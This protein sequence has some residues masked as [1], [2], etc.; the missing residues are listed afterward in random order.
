MDSGSNS[1]DNKLT[2]SLNKSFSDD[3]GNFTFKC[4]DLN[5]RK[6]DV[7]LHFESSVAVATQ[8][9][10]ECFTENLELINSTTVDL[11]QGNQGSGVW[12]TRRLIRIDEP[13]LLRGIEVI[14]IGAV[15]VANTT[16]IESAKKCYSNMNK[17]AI[18]HQKNTLNLY[19][20]ANNNLDEKNYESV[21]ELHDELFTGL[22]ELRKEYNAAVSDEVK[23]LSKHLH[24][25]KQSYNKNPTSELEEKI[26]QLNDMKMAFH[27]AT[28]KQS[29]IEGK[30]VKFV[31]VVEKKFIL[32]D[33]KETLSV[34]QH[35]TKAENRELKIINK[36]LDSTKYVSGKSRERLEHKRGKIL[37]KLEKVEDIGSIKKLT[38][39][40]KLAKLL[41]KP[42]RFIQKIISKITGIP[43]ELDAVIMKLARPPSAD[44]MVNLNTSIQK[45]LDACGDNP[46]VL[47]RKDAMVGYVTDEPLL[48]WGSTYEGH[49]LSNPANWVDITDIS[50][51]I[52]PNGKAHIFE[53][54]EEAQGIERDGKV[55]GGVPSGLRGSEGYNT[56]AANMLKTTVSR[57]TDIL[58]DDAPVIDEA[59]SVERW[60][61]GQL[62]TVDAAK[63]ALMTMLTQSSS[64]V[65]KLHD[66]M[67]L[68]ALLIPLVKDRK[69]AKTH[70][71]NVETALNE[72]INAGNSIKG[73]GNIKY[74][75]E[76]L[77]GIKTNLMQT[78]LAVNEGAVGKMAGLKM[79]WHTATYDYN[80][81]AVPKYNKILRDTLEKLKN[82]VESERAGFKDKQLFDRLGAVVQVGLDLEAVWAK[83]DFSDADVGNNQVKAPSLWGVLDS[84]LGVTVNTHCKSAKDRAG[85]AEA[86]SVEILQTIMANLADHKS[87]LNQK[88]DECV[89]VI[90]NGEVWLEL[91]MEKDFIVS[92]A[93]QWDEI[94]KIIDEVKGKSIDEIKGIIKEKKLD[95]INDSMIAL[96]VDNGRI[97]FLQQKQITPDSKVAKFK[98]GVKKKIYFGVSGIS[99]TTP[100]MERLSTK[101]SFNSFPRMAPESIYSNREVSPGVLIERQRAKRN[102]RI[103]CQVAMSITKKN[104]GVPGNKLQGG[105]ALKIYYSG[106]DRDYVLNKLQEVDENKFKMS[107]RDV[108]GLEQLNKKTADNLV[109]LADSFKRNK[110]LSDEYKQKKY[111][112]IIKGVEEI[113]FQSFRPQMHVSA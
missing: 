32:M 27:L 68:T 7:I 3:S 81:G 73:K 110:Y 77:E 24:T 109:I 15:A 112:E 97:N 84:L 96:G 99:K 95:K 38:R 43:Q 29:G 45:E 100:R 103:A 76:D 83:N 94:E 18:T 50:L 35:L 28:T 14:D 111:L 61:I 16:T 64:K 93:F 79:G 86:N 101:D 52:T 80:D 75:V 66:N 98:A 1:L 65:E 69:L 48:I 26:N 31:A 91:N 60:R 39:S 47:S 104:T 2:Y 51:V 30:V 56:R 107:F 70:K 10:I 49:A 19:Q 58:E 5:G 105:S 6:V 36:E 20:N 63:D 4:E 90:E 44:E 108:L 13:E 11:I 40:T 87:E 92:G 22:N 12:D 34:Q 9:A 62:P 46:E 102:R 33:R 21:G 53:T 8:K 54:K 72:L 89:D 59:S 57:Y 37:K 88:F 42:A 55:V 82:K 67:L 113:K 85:V 17:L 41:L 74:S 106:F 25:L 78:N 23:L 71:Y